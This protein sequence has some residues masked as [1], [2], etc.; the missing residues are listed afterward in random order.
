MTKDLEFKEAMA[1]MAAAVCIITTAGPSGAYGL[2]ATAV[3]S[4]SANPPMLLVC[5]NRESK[6]STI[7]QENGR[8]RVN[9][10]AAD[11]EALSEAFSR[12]GL[13]V[14]E[15]FAQSDEWR[16]HDNECPMLASATAS[17]ECKVSFSMN[18]DSHSIF[19]GRV[20]GV[21]LSNTKSSLCY[22]NRRYHPLS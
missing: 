20:Q 3:C 12:S 9:I 16:T 22:F 1:R 13:S 18:V 8:F 10:L 5:I 14:E 6:A 17:V 2:T 19:F 11:Q 4:V 21:A 15:R 7:V